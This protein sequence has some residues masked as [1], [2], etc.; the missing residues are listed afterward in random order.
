M[1][2]HGAQGNTGLSGTSAFL[3]VE[4]SARG[5]TWVE[6]MDASQKN[7]ALMI[8]QSQNI[9]DVLARVLAA[10]GST[11]ETVRNDLN[12]TLKELMTDPSNLRGMDQAVDRL[13]KAIRDSEKITI[14]GDYDVD[15]AT[16]TT[17][18]M[19]FL[20]AHGSSPEFYIPDRQL[21]GYGPN[22]TAFEQIIADGTRLIITVDCGTASHE[23]VSHANSLGCDVLVLDHHQADEKLPPAFAVVNPNRQDDLSGLGH[24]AAVGVVFLFLVAMSRK[25]REQKTQT[26]TGENFDL[27]ALLDLVALGTVCDVVPLTGL[28]KAYVKRGLE[29]M[30]G[31]ENTG[32]RALC[33]IAGLTVAPTPYHLGF[34]L[35]P[36]IN[37]GG[38]IGRSDM[39]TQLLTTEDDNFATTLAAELDGLNTERQQMQQTLTEEALAQADATLAAN[40]DAPFALAHGNGWHKGLVGLVAAKLADQ[41][42][43]PSIVI[44]WDKDSNGSGSA[45]SIQGVDLGAAIRCAV[46][47]GILT[48]GG[49][50]AMAAGFTLP[51]DNLEAFSSYLENELL[52]EVTRATATRILKFDAALMASS[53]TLEL[54]DELDKAG[55]YGAGN[56]QPRFAFAGHRCR[57]PK[58]VGEKHVKCTVAAN[59]G[60]RLD[61]IAFNSAQNALG[62]LLLKSNGSILHFSGHLRRNDWGGRQKLE[63]HIDDAAIPG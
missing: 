12:P 25:L 39:G 44:A 42:R 55:P 56:S 57:Y 34:V 59:D 52:K 5:Y 54:M 7:I 14:F 29:V 19:R 22:K 2:S 60:S 36:R 63:L 6:R 21:E 30:H 53:A 31:R 49:G 38:R 48:R 61:A 40:P 10:R 43:R 41:F 58:I 24:L 15:G 17:L 20:Q 47:R 23:Q 1:S 3:R 45:R 26:T 33:D 4:N 27:L 11:P 16:S 35:G 62:E 28:N 8:A 18:L 9:P 32:L 51:H 13:L 37:A 50:H 46:E